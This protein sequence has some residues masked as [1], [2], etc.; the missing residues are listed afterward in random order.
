MYPPQSM[1]KGTRRVETDAHPACR[2]NVELNR[3][4]RCRSASCKPADTSRWSCPRSP[5]GV[6]SHCRGWP[7]ASRGQTAYRRKAV[8]DRAHILTITGPFPRRSWTRLLKSISRPIRCS[9]ARS[10]INFQRF[11]VT[12]Q[13]LIAIQVQGLIVIENLTK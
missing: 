7:S 9:P 3:P 2:N 11:L 6:S 5:E 12:F 8:S 13:G 1:A 10:W 4:A